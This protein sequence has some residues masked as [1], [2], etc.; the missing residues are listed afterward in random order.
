M[1]AAKRYCMYCYY[2]DGTQV[3][4]ICIVKTQ[5]SILVTHLEW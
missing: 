5:D 4:Q 2:A 1:E 3:K